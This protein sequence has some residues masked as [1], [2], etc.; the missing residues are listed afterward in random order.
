MSDGMERYLWRDTLRSDRPL[1]CRRFVIESILAIVESFL[2]CRHIGQ[3]IVRPR[4]HGLDRGELALL[5]LLDGLAQN[6]LYHFPEASDLKTDGKLV[7]GN[8]EVG[9]EGLDIVI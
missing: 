4:S 2:Q 8:Y 9:G 5:H 6:L 7:D 1:V 3:R